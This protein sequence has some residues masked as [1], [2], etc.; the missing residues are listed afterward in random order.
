MDFNNYFVTSDDIWNTWIIENDTWRL[1]LSDSGVPLEFNGQYEAEGYLEHNGIPKYLFN[2]N[3]E[4]AESNLICFDGLTVAMQAPRV[5]VDFSKLYLNRSSVEIEDLI[6]KI[7]TEITE[8]KFQMPLEVAFDLMRKILSAD[9][10]GKQSRYWVETLRDKPTR[11]EVV[12]LRVSDTAGLIVRS[13]FASSH[14]NRTYQA[15]LSGLEGF[16]PT[17]KS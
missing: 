16:R 8:G 9:D 4:R 5:A 7:K 15:I 10:C 14:R 1:M 12:R 6:T 13:I 17:R 3:K 11:D 2:S